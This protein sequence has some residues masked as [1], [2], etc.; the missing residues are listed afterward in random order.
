MS[1]ICTLCACIIPEPQTHARVR[2]K[3]RA[4]QQFGCMLVPASFNSESSL[5]CQKQNGVLKWR[6]AICG[7]GF[8]WFDGSALA[9]HS[10]EQTLIRWAED[11]TNSPPFKSAKADV[12]FYSSW[13]KLLPWYYI[14]IHTGLYGAQIW[15]RHQT[16]VLLQQNSSVLWI[17]QLSGMGSIE[18]A[19]MR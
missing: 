9:S 11:L 18:P 8:I 4:A 6:Y 7:L 12:R 15:G 16:T 3:P 10:V 5:A 17:I 19:V 2:R 14:L 13:Q 1:P